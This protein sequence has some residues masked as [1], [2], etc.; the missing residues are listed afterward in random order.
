M[1]Y[2]DTLLLETPCYGSQ[3]HVEKTVAISQRKILK[4]QRATCERGRSGYV[5]IK[6]HQLL[7]NKYVSS[8]TELQLP[9]KGAF[10]LQ[11]ITPTSTQTR[12]IFSK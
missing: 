8:Q 7:F 2:G 6:D 4:R 1:Q 10:P 5:I 12:K 3:H 9:S 11:V